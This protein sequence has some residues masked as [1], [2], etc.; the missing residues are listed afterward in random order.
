MW[1]RIAKYKGGDARHYQGNNLAGKAKGYRCK[2]EPAGVEGQQSGPEEVLI[3]RM[4]QVGRKR[5]KGASRPKE[6]E[7]S[8]GREEK[9]NR[10]KR[11][12]GKRSGE[13]QTGGGGGAA[14]G[15]I[16]LPNPGADSDAACGK[17]PPGPGSL[18]RGGWKPVSSHVPSRPHSPSLPLPVRSPRA[19]NSTGTCA[20]A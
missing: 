1:A 17:A 3:R 10:N 5:K 13:A 7:E 16:R 19:R 9:S 18:I 20:F 6:K 15:K 2:D 8:G 11:T 4:Y 12:G 14:P